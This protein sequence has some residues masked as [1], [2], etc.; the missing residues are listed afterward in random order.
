MSVNSSVL[1]ESEIDSATGVILE[2]LEAKQDD[3]VQDMIGKIN[4]LIT[5]LG[6]ADSPATDLTPVSEQPSY[7]TDASA[8]SRA[9][10]ST[11]GRSRAVV[12]HTNRKTASGKKKKTPFELWN[13]KNKPPPKP[14]TIKLTE[15]QRN[16]TTERL[17]ASKTNKDLDGAQTFEA[18]AAEEDVVGQP[19]T[20]RTKTQND[21][22]QGYV[23]IYKR[24]QAVIEKAQRKKAQI[25]RQRENEE[26]APCTF[27]PNMGLSHKTFKPGHKFRQPVGTVY[28]R[29]NEYGQMK[30]YRAN[31][32]RHWQKK[33]E[34]K[35]LTFEPKLNSNTRRILERTAARNP[36]KTDLLLAVE[37]RERKFRVAGDN[38]DAGHEEET[39][40]PRINARSRKLA[41]KGKVYDRLY[42]SAIQSEESIMGKINTYFDETVNSNFDRPAVL[43]NKV[44]NGKGSITN[45]ERT[46]QKQGVLVAPNEFNENVIQWDE[47]MGFLRATLNL[48]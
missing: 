47:S 3:S 22:L 46:L 32:R 18:L 8:E 38:R 33:I 45:R 10:G 27:K 11:R 36:R 23:P 19:D 5:R 1:D 41:R 6:S 35:E 48:D 40:Q 4:E 30:Q 9:S 25:E 34:E 28:D 24:Y 31:R 37:E 21:K 39:F 12:K 16:A 7:T 26:L 44:R 13:Q 14:K 42:Q 20:T 29:C 15:A 2:A 43:K 17:L